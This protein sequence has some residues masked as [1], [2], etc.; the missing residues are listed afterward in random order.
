[1]ILPLLNLYATFGFTDEDKANTFNVF[2]V[3]ITNI[4]DIQAS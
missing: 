3:S 4:D 2:F 1:M